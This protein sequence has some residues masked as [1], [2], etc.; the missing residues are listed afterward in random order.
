M[1]DLTNRELAQVLAALRFWQEAD[2]DGSGMSHF[3]DDEPLSLDEIDFLCEKLNGGPCQP[4]TFLG[5][6]EKADAVE[7]DDH[8]IR[9]F[10]TDFAEAKQATDEL[11]LEASMCDEDGDMHEYEVSLIE[12]QTATYNTHDKSWNVGRYTIKLIEFRK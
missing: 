7:I 12:A 4:E 3:E 5:E 6:L 9:Y 10:H 1:N 11:V 8:F 2:V